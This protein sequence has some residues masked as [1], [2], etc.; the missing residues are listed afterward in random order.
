MSPKKP[1]IT[2]YQL[3]LWSSEMADLYNSLEGEIIRIII[4]QL[5][6]GYKD[7]TLWQAQKLQELRL[8]N[9]DVAR[10]VSEVTEVSETVV[11]NIFE[12]AGRRMIDDVDNAMSQAFE[13]KPYPEYLNQIM[14]GYRN[15]V[16][17]ELDNYDNPS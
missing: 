11:T 2:P 4:K 8:F 13:K 10:Y 9:N 3:D 17:S 16:W 5:N 14:R 15:Q 12:E 7:I 1:K 6:S